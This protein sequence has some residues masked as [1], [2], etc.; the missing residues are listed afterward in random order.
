MK[1]DAYSPVFVVAMSVVAVGGMAYAAQ[2]KWSD[3][4]SVAREG[5]RSPSKRS[6]TWLDYYR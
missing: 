4:D 3:G 6:A 2:D 5:F 1:G